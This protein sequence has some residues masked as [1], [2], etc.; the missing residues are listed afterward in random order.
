LNQ[1]I[2]WIGTIPAAVIACLASAAGAQTAFPVKPVRLIVPF[3]AGGSADIV[4][5][6]LSGRF[7]EVLGVQVVV[8]NR[9]GASAMIG[10]ELG[11]KS[12]PDG[13]T[14]VLGGFSSHVVNRF[15]YPKLP[16]DPVKDFAPITLLTVMPNLLAAHPSVPARNVKELLALARSRPGEITYASS[17]SGSS[18]HLA[19]VLLQTMTGVRLTHVPYKSGAP[20]ITDLLGGHVVSMFITLPAATP[21]VRAGRLRPLGLTSAA[22]VASLP[23]VATIAESGLAGYDVSTWYAAYAPAGTPKEPLARLHGALAKALQSPDVK[24]RLADQGAEVGGG[25]P[26]ALAAF[27]AKESERWGPIVRKAGVKAD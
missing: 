5:R 12:P 24:Q 17:G 7:A 25:T 16:Y 2:G 6:Q 8:D 20:A 3:A 9:P 13:H 21:H 15:L 18:Q 26:E 1:R 10:V 23:E 22:R 11:A 27:Q 4:A 14:I 19:G